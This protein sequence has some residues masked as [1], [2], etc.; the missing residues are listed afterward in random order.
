MTQGQL[1]RI[2]RYTA[3][4]CATSEHSSLSKDVIYQSLRSQLV[5]TTTVSL[6]QEY[7]ILYLP[8]EMKEEE[9]PFH[10]WPDRRPYIDFPAHR[11]G[12]FVRHQG[13]FRKC[14]EVTLKDAGLTVKPE[15]GDSRGY[16]CIMTGQ[17]Y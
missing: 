17:A 1:Q 13:M 15:I 14:Q 8:P 4:Q 12:Q 5:L 16:E 7:P 2:L 10:S 3:E 6:T 11:Y 9:L